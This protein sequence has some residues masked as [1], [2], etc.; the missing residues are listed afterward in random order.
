M[1]KLLMGLITS[2]LIAAAGVPDSLAC[3]RI[4][5]NA[6]GK[7]IITPRAMDLDQQ[8]HAQ[9]SVSPRGLARASDTG[10]GA[11]LRWTSKYGNVSV[12]GGYGDSAVAGPALS[13]AMA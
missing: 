2:G 12:T 1:P 4:L 7:A 10:S 8:D 11:P 13:Q 6:N 9:I 3:S 5:S